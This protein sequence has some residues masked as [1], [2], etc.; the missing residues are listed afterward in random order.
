M[1]NGEKNPKY[2][3]YIA[4]FS[5]LARKKWKTTAIL[6]M[7][8]KFQK[9]KYGYNG[10]KDQGF[11][12]Q[13]VGPLIFWSSLVSKV[14]SKP[15]CVK[16]GQVM[17]DAQGPPKLQVTVQEPIIM[18]RPSVEEAQIDLVAWGLF[19]QERLAKPT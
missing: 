18:L 5:S 14:G 13:Q 8:A 4:I 11:S 17:E 19:L 16:E 15:K 12:M 7:L 1:K 2:R 9:L 3:Q 10:K 6:S